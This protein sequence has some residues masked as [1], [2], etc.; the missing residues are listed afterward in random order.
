MNWKEKK[1]V[2][3]QGQKVSWLDFSNIFIYSW[4]LNS[5]ISGILVCSNLWEWLKYESLIDLR[6][7]SVPTEAF[8]IWCTWNL[9]NSSCFH[10]RGPLKVP[11][12]THLYRQGE[13]L[14]LTVHVFMCGTHH[15]IFNI[16]VWLPPCISPLEGKCYMHVLRWVVGTPS[17]SQNAHVFM[18]RQL[19]PPFKKS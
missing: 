2:T 7:N 11:P 4:P 18:G 19:G 12:F 14:G 16:H 17:G 6:K 1:C 15:L 8:S 3:Y 9:C 5:K 10:R 13:L